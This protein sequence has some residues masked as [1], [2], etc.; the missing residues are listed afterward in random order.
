MNK[1]EKKAKELVER[2]LGNNQK[3]I[4]PNNK[5]SSD[6]KYDYHFDLSLWETTFFP[7]AKQGALICVD[8][9]IKMLNE[10]QQSEHSDA[11]WVIEVYIQEEK[12][13]KQAINKM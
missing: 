8:R 10:L 11:F 9:S 12:Q 3:P 6:E 7:E 4:K 5:A 2:F 13:V 1:A